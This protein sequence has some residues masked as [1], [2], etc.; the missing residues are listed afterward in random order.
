ME[1]KRINVLYQ[2]KE[3]ILE[4]SPEEY[5]TFDIFM[6]RI[7]DEF[8]KTQL[9]QLMAMNSSEQFVILTPENYLKIINEDIQEGLKLF[10]SEMVKTS[11]TIPLQ[12]NNQKEE[13][14]QETFEDE[15]FI[16]ESDNKDNNEINNLNIEREE[17]IN[18]I[19]EEKKVE[20]INI[21]NNNIENEKEEENNLLSYKSVVLRGENKFMEGNN[22]EE[23]FDDKIKNILGDFEEDDENYYIKN[24]YILTSKNIDK[25][26]FQTEKCSICGYKLKGIKY[27]CCICDQR[28][29][30]EE[31]ELYHNH[32]CFKYKNNFICSLY[33]V[34][35]F[36]S[37]IYEY[38][39]PHESTMYSKFFRKEYDLKIEPYSDLSFSLRPNKSINIPIK[40][41][42]YSKENLDSDQFIIICK[43]QKNIYLSTQKEKFKITGEE[44]ILDIKCVTPDRTCPKETILFEIYSQEL[45]IKSSR[46]LVIEYNIEVN[47]DSEDDKLN[48]ELKNDDSIYCFNKEHKRIGL[49]LMKSSENQ[50]KIKDIFNSLFVNNWDNNKALKALK[51]KK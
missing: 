24:K 11:D 29:L 19:E 3:K 46:R 32:P 44:F 9:Y 25:K 4:L 15:D 26:T 33:E 18:K 7:N 21:I 13:E 42:N 39:L 20:N 17:N 47:F 37:K 50:Y 43:N 1:K 10:M 35:D 16:I 12:E 40:I 49:Q 27:I 14:K 30:C 5:I 31:C 45:P 8:Q 23:N 22:D 36:I 34:C 2:G 41:I 6:K 51:K 38:K 28:I 48:M